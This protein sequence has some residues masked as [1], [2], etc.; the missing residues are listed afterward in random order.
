[1]ARK[2]GSVISWSTLGHTKKKLVGI[3]S[4]H[5]LCFY[6]RWKTPGQRVDRW[7]TIW[8]S[9]LSFP[10]AVRWSSSHRSARRRPGSAETGSWSARGGSWGVSCLGWTPAERKTKKMN[11]T[12]MKTINWAYHMYRQKYIA[13]TKEVCFIPEPFRSSK[14]E[15]DNVEADNHGTCREPTSQIFSS[16]GIQDTAKWQ[17]CSTTQ[18]P[19]FTP[20][21]TMRRAIG[22]CPWPRD[23]ELSLE[24]PK[25]CKTKRRMRN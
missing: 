1:M 5:L 15:Q 4:N 3:N 25:P 7:G 18:V 22:P 2:K 14:Y 16:V 24:P 12:A 8:L 11:K 21:S 10:L 23:S 13:W 20:L 9:W 19:S 6:S 17:F